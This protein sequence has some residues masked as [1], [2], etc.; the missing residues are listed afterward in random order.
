MTSST[1]LCEGNS[2]FNY[3]QPFW[4]ATESVPARNRFKKQARSP[5]SC[6]LCTSILVQEVI[7]FDM[8]AFILENGLLRNDPEAIPMR[9]KQRA[10]KWAPKRRTGCLTCR[11]RHVKCDEAKPACRRCVIASR[12]C[13][14]PGYLGSSSKSLGG[15]AADGQRGP[16]A[17]AL[18]LRQPNLTVSPAGVKTSEKEMLQFYFF[19]KVAALSMAGVFDQKRRCEEGTNLS[20]VT[21]WS[22]EEG[23]RSLFVESIYGSSATTVFDKEAG[24]GLIAGLYAKGLFIWRE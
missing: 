1:I 11:Q 7:C 22:E 20:W 12:D 15:T 23:L 2:S 3:L 13:I 9:P 4:R 14:G 18:V 19:R 21:E 5:S 10:R 8:A 6:K 17:S 16:Q 24:F